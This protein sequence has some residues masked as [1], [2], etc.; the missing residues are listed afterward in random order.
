MSRTSAKAEP[1]PGTDLIV[2][3]H[4]GPVA[5]PSR[6]SYPHCASRLREA[7]ETAHSSSERAGDDHE[8]LAELQSRYESLLG[9][10]QRV[11]VDRFVWAPDVKQ[12]S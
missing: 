10:S 7:S 12:S 4:L 1:S 8:V 11:A 9:P 6:G 5:E 3:D 2:T